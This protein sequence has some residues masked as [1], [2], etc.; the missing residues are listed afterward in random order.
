MANRLALVEQSDISQLPYLQAV[1]K[2]IWQLH[3]HVQLLI[4]HKTDTIENVAEYIVPKHTQVLINY[5]A[6]GRDPK[7]WDN[8]IAF[9]PERFLG[10]NVDYKGKDFQFIPFGAG[11]KTCPGLPLGVRMVHLMLASLLHYFDWELSGGLKAEE[12]DMRDK[13]GVTL[14]TLVPLRAIPSEARD[15]QCA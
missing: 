5:W 7:V 6:I 1:V 8:P 14:Q 12:M 13:F 10:C 11:W 15:L 2:E 9:L 4:P 3:P